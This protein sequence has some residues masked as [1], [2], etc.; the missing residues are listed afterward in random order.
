VRPSAVAVGASSLRPTPTF[1]DSVHFEGH[2]FL[3]PAAP[4]AYRFPWAMAYSGSP[5]ATLT[6]DAPSLR[7]AESITFELR[8]LVSYDQAIEHHAQITL[9]GAPILDATWGGDDE[10]ALTASL[11][12]GLLQATGN[13]LG[14][15]AVEDLGLPYDLFALA[16]FDVTGQRS[17]RAEN[18]ALAFAARSSASVALTGF[19]APPVVLDVSDPARPALL[20]GARILVAADRTFEV[21]FQA[22]ADASGRRYFAAV[23]QAVPLLPSRADEVPAGS[24]DEVMIVA[25]GLDAALAPLV[26]ARQ[27]QG[28]RV[29]VADADAVADAFGY[30]DHGPQGLQRYLAQLSPAPRHVLLVGKP[31]VDPHDYLQTGVPDAV[32]TVLTFAAGWPRFA[33][34]DVALVAGPDGRTPFAAVGRLPVSSA[35]ELAAWVQKLVAPTAGAS[36]QALWVADAIDPSSGEDDPFFRQESDRLIP[37][38]P[39]LTPT[40]VYLPEAG[41]AELLAALAAAPELVAYH[42]HADAL[43]WSQTGLFTSADVGQLPAA[44]PF[45]LVTADCY[46][47][48]FAQ[49][50][51]DPLAQQLA[52]AAQGGA[53]A[54]FSASTL[55]DE[56]LDPLLDDAI[57][58]P[59]ADPSLRTVGDYTLRAQRA[60][61]ELQGPASVL[62]WDYNL[63]GD[64]ASPLPGR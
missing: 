25:P 46:D 62:L 9:N 42:G 43:D 34:S 36:G 28:L 8:G 63:I 30:G 27:A 48:M 6:F 19:S 14:I 49:P 64:P 20:E 44:P 61:A 54:A 31:S 37:L 35:D 1:A 47:G 11:P 55:V 32:P 18:D 57:F 23:P 60:L 45:L 21:R 3:D 56:G 52:Q 5:P 24:A 29:L 10:V 39:A 15:A 4:P 2:T 26:T 22:P 7:S 33:V 13:V 59:L 38:L 58:P 51:I 16:A 53:L 12:A 17:Y 50:N 41:K 40:R